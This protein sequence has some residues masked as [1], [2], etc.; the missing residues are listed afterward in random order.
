M[1]L[2]RQ[3]REGHVPRPERVS[4]SSNARTRFGSNNSLGALCV[5]CGSSSEVKLPAVFKRNTGCPADSAS[6]IVSQRGPICL[7]DQMSREVETNDNTLEA[8]VVQPGLTGLRVAAFEGRHAQEMARLIARHGGEAVLAPSMA[9]APL[10]QNVR[11][12][13][14]A[15]RLLGR[16]LSVVVFLTGV[17]TRTLFEVLETRHA[18]DTIV[19]ALN[20]TTVVA[21]GPKSVAALRNF[22]VTIALTVPEPSTWREILETLDTSEQCPSLQGLTV[23]VQEYGAPNF[24]FLAALKKRGAEVLQVPV[25]RWTLPADTTPLRQA[26][27]SLVDGRCDVALFT[28]SMQVSHLF[29]VAEQMGVGNALRDALSQ[30][31]VASIGPWCSQ[32]IRERF[33]QVDL[34]AA[35]SKMTHLVSDASAQ[36]RAL[37]QKK[38]TAVA[39]VDRVIPADW[40]EQKAQ[41]KLLDKV[42]SSAFMRACRR[43]P[44]DYTPIWLMRQ[45]GR[46]MPEYREIRARNSFL[47]L[48]KNSDLAAE[49]TVTAA[50]RLGVDAAIIFADILLIVEPMGLGLRFEKGDGPVIDGLIRT[51]ADVQRLLEVEPQ[52]SLTFVFDAVR[53]AR[54]GL[55]PD[56]P[57]IGFA[58]APFTLASY[59]VEG[60]ASK[61]Y[62][63]TKTLM[64]REPNAWHEMMASIS[65]SLI[66]YLNGQIAAGAQAVQLFDSWV[67]CLSPGDYREFVLPHTRSVIN[68]IQSAVPVINFSTGTSSYLELV[69]QAGGDVIGVDWRVDLGEAWS[70]I[71]YDVGIQGNLDP[72]VLF[73]DRG[74]VVRS[75]KQILEKAG[76]RSGYIFNLGHGILPET[77]MD[78]VLALVEAVH[79]LSQRWDNGGIG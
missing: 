28:N 17:G 74:Y 42:E 69:R 71:G 1:L 59:I 58:G 60:G 75:A 68:G 19:T 73:A 40:G 13:E 8:V 48:C 46:Y 25:Y 10:G 3:E 2:N 51:S 23:A 66:K 37:L 21:R 53:K 45:A 32:A 11:A 62:R 47:E 5:L 44:T 36:A 76:G 15:Q 38:R 55:R 18:R 61:N 7:E 4:D 67:G 65:R 52:E 14:F 26:I 30:V 24:D 41:P 56:I 33:V 27:Q 9:E 43:L 12:F 78:N 49:V 57:L 35:C 64:Y 16:E 79:E 70:R 29:Q 34:E 22:G 72:L 63:Y 54:A 77:P 31:V 20:Q 6:V 39:P 50:H